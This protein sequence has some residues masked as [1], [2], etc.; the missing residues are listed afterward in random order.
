MANRCSASIKQETEGLTAVARNK[1]WGFINSKGVVVVPLKYDGPSE[2]E[3]GLACFELDGKY[4]FVN[5]SGKE[6]VAMKYESIDFFSN[7]LAGVM[8][9][10]KWGYVNMQGVMVIKPQFDNAGRF[11]KKGRATV[12]IKEE[13][14]WIDKT[15]KILEKQ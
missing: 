12:V 3:D 2:F 10:G 7:G 9:N 11:N 8:L 4:G 15:G 14:Y 13:Y 1:K 5:K 6:V